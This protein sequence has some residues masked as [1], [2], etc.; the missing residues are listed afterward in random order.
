MY[1]I[2][3]LINILDSQAPANQSLDDIESVLKSISSGISI[4]YAKRQRLYDIVIRLK[5]SPHEQIKEA[6][7]KVA[8]KIRRE[9]LT[10]AQTFYALHNEDSVVVKSSIN[11]HYEVESTLVTTGMALYQWC[12]MII[13]DDGNAT[14][15]D[16]TKNKCTIGNYFSTRPVT[17]ESL[18]IYGIYDLKNTDG[19]FEGTAEQVLCQFT[20]PFSAPCLVSIAKGTF[21]HWNAHHYYDGTEIQWNKISAG[22]YDGLWAYGGALQVFIPLNDYQKKS[23]AKIAQFMQ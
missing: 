1:N 8:K 10:D 18:G 21:D 19:K 9:R 13:N 23:L 20:L 17:P 22:N 12:K 6:A 2:E 3:S 16:P 5:N 4:P 15:Y 7:S 11:P 14:L